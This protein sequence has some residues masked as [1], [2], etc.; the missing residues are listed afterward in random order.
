MNRL[1]EE[2]A[3]AIVFANTKRRPRDRA[4]SLI[5]VAQAFRYLVD[6]YDSVAA[7]AKKADLSP[8]M[9]REFLQILQLPREVKK[10]VSERR[11][12]SID[13]AYRL[14]MLQDRSQ[15]IEAAQAMA[16]LPSDDVRDV[17]RLVRH[18]DL[19]IQEATKMVSESKPKGLHIFIM[20][21]DDEM[22]AEIIAQARSMKVQPAELVK[23][24]VKD[25]LRSKAGASEK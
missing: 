17:I 7:T 22:Y 10:L 23:Q 4:E 11:I 24:I 6:L 1:D 19:S 14:S 8:E 20:D 16:A 3:L 18:T 15:Q 12:D 9:V 5:T 25:W 13:V 2:T 21:F